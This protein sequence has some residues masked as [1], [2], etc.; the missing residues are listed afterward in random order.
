ML[1]EACVV[2]ERPVGQSGLCDSPT[3]VTCARQLS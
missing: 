1:Q 3:L 2:V